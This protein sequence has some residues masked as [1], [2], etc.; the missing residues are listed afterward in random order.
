MLI[1]VTGGAASGKSEFAEQLLMEK[2]DVRYY[3]ATMHKDDSEDAQYRIARH[4]KLREGKGFITVEQETGLA[5]LGNSY[6]K[7]RPGHLTGV[8]M[9][10]MSNLLAN[11][12]YFAKRENV[13]EGI[14]ADITVLSEKCDCLVVITSEIGSD[15]QEYDDFTKEYITNLASIN[16]KLATLA[17]E[18]YEIVYAVPIR[19]K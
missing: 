5:N 19:L 3:V 11:E 4:R 8:L 7:T 17:D 13:V 12:M 10:C 16:A 18:V 15:G 1:V 14:V 9:E 6:Q 2:C